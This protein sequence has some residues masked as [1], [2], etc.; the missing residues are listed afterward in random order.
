MTAAP[1]IIGRRAGGEAVYRITLESAA[2]FRVEMIT[3]GA[4]ITA[5]CHFDRSGHRG[6]VVL[7]YPFLED[8]LSNPAY[9]GS[10]V[11]RIAGRIRNGCIDL[12]SRQVFLDRSLHP[13][14]LHSG[15]GGLHMINWHIGKVGLTFAKLH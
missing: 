2:G 1:E 6:N 9:V 8:Y 10:T 14:A 3:L 4:T 12:S 15:P 13:H 11:G 5:V 7:A